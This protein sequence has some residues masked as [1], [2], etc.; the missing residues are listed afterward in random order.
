M[1]ITPYYI[2]ICGLSGSAVSSTLSHKLDDFQKRVIGHKVCV[3][4]SYATVA[5][6]FLVLRRAE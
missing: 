2:V 4:V 5:E 1:R 3:S 6:M